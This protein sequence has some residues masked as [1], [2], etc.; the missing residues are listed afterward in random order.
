LQPKYALTASNGKNAIAT[1][2]PNATLVIHQA[3][4]E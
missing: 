4:L 2:A 1:L 3:T